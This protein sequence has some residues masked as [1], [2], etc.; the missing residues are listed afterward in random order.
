MVLRNQTLRSK[1]QVYFA[2]AYGSL[3]LFVFTI[4]GAAAIYVL[5]GL[6]RA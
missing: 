6:L 3:A 5:Q 4:K 2:E 1:P